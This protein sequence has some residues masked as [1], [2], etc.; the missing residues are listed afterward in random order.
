MIAR[1]A[2]E[3]LARAAHGQCG[4]PVGSSRIFGTR[5]RSK[6][7]VEIGQYFGVM[8][9]SH[10][11]E[12]SG[13]GHG[14]ELRADIH[15]GHRHVGVGMLDNRYFALAGDLHFV[16]RGAP[17]G[18]FRMNSTAG[19]TLLGWTGGPSR[20]RSSVARTGTVGKLL[21]RQVRPFGGY[22]LLMYRRTTRSR[23]RMERTH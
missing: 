11:S 4:S 19:R 17:G 18:V 8:E 23:K 22:A 9:N 20:I 15:A 7:D 6:P 21:R 10:A 14:L 2:F 16:E 12:H 1:S 13:V 5:A 3:R